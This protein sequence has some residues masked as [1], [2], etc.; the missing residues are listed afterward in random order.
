MNFG[1]T[2]SFRKLLTGLTVVPLLAATGLG[3]FLS[4]DAL[5]SYENM[6]V[7][8]SLEDVSKAGGDLLIALPMEGGAPA[9]KRS[10]MRQNTDAKY[11]ALI[12]AYDRV[13][14]M[15]LQDK[16]L[17]DYKDQL[18]KNYSR[19]SEYRSIVDA[20]KA[21]PV[22]PVKYLQPIGAM[23]LE[24]TGRAGEMIDDRGLSQS[25]QGFYAMLQTNDAY[26]VINR[27]GQVYTKSGSLN[28]DAYIRFAMGYHQA[29]IYNKPMQAFVPASI[30][31][32]Y[33]DFWE[34][35]NGRFARKTVE[36]MAA[37]KTYTPSAEDL[38]T[39]NNAMLERRNLVS[40][41]L[42]KTSAEL[43]SL[44]NSKLADARS[45]LITMISFLTI[46]IAFT[47]AFS[48]YVARLLSGAIRRISAR[49]GQL[50]TGDKQN[51]IP[52]LERSDEIGQIA[53]SVEVF[54]LAAIRNDELE[55]EAASNRQQ[56]EQERAEVQRRA[57]AEA[58]KRLNEATGSLASGLRR[59][60]AGDLLCEI[61]EN[62]APQFEALRQDFNSSVAQLRNA[63]LLVG[64][65][66]SSVNAGSGEISHASND[67]ARRTETQAASLEQTAAALEEITSNVQAAT[68]RTGEAKNL[69]HEA[70]QKAEHSSRVVG[71]AV[72]AMERIEQ[73]SRQIT[74]IISVI[75]EIAFQTNLLALNAGVEAARAGE[76]GKGFAVVAQEVRELAQRS[77]NAAKEIKQLINNSELAVSEGVKLVH[78]TGTGLGEIARVVDAVN[79]HMEEIAKAA[80]EQSSS[81]GEVNTAVNHMDQATQQ[82]AAMVEEMSAASAGLAEE[83]RKLT[84][85][86]TNFQTEDRNAMTGSSTQRRYG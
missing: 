36:D 28:D 65:A 35:A 58:E 34:S 86:L 66:A 47:I 9:E 82:N 18:V 60:A 24:M 40:D 74:Q 6:K 67:L 10:E 12:A 30:M 31:S 25:I 73:A 81:L 43:V 19:I 38:S 14:A 71:N 33:N 55:A 62:F 27:L 78:D 46:L 17:T 32:Q 59:M 8:V 5:K 45:S 68:R 49:M 23:G 4:W 50:A 63:L 77:A 54:R 51:A 3:G 53:Q 11:K 42:K 85:L 22:T 79:H 44:A 83:A 1:A 70:H 61:H 57:E 69:V 48:V 7:A 80:S 64:Q 52:Y 37:F 20:G 41:L 26:L 16:F 29:R 39:W 15:G 75:D 84:D 56:A 76:A 72:N 13:T 2:L 21:E